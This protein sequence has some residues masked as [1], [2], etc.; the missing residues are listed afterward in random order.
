V[1]QLQFKLRRIKVQLAAHMHQSGSTFKKQST[2]NAFKDLRKQ[3]QK[4]RL[5]GLFSYNVFDNPVYVRSKKIE[6][7]ILKMKNKQKVEQQK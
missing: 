2:I 7:K 3:G 6:Q 4:N 1:T 5:K